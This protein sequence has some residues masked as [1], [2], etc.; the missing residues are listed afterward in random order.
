MV[1]AARDKTLGDVLANVELKEEVRSIMVEA[2][3]VAKASGVCLP[4]DIV[5]VSLL[6]AHDFPAAAKTSFQRD[7]ER[8]DKLDE[9][10]LFGGAMIRL[11]ERINVLVPGTRTVCAILAKK[12]PAR[13]NAVD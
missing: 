1:C 13:P 2:S 12:K 5:E 8:Q 6:K 4:D 3:A 7:F 10:D 11:A 9:R